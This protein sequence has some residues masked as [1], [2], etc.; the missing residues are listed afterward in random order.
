MCLARVFV[1]GSVASP[2]LENKDS[3]LYLAVPN[4]LPIPSL[5]SSRVWEAWVEEPLLGGGV[6][7]WESGFRIHDYV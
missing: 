5:W 6:G 3:P 2:S 7:I 1:V 4:P